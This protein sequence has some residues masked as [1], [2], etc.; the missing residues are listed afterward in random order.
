MKDSP[1]CFGQYDKNRDRSDCAN[2][3]GENVLCRICKTITK[4]AWK[5]RRVKKVLN[6]KNI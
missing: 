6:I 4:K 5:I 1:N 2:L 3:Q